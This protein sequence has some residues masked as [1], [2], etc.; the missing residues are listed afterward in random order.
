MTNCCESM[1]PHIIGSAF[2]LVLVSSESPVNEGGVPVV[3]TSGWGVALELVPVS[4]AV[5]TV[6][7]AWVSFIVPSY[8]MKFEQNDTTAWPKGERVIRLVYTAPD[9]RVFKQDTDMMLEI[10]R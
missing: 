10:K 6:A 8:S 9:T 7:G 3:N 1:Q 5:I 2:S 4:G